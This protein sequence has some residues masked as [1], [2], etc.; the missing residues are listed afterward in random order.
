M[1]TDPPPVVLVVEERVVGGRT[2]LV[3]VARPV[4]PGEVLVGAASAG[5][6]GAGMRRVLD[7]EGA[8]PRSR[9]ASDRR[10][11]G[12]MP[13]EVPGRLHPIWGYPTEAVRA[14]SPQAAQQWDERLWGAL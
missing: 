5:G 7:E 11:A 10:A 3:K 14:V 13:G 9:P 12:L 2:V 4:D 8:P 6:L 1:T